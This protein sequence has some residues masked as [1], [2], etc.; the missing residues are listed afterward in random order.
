MNTIDVF[1]LIV[2]LFFLVRGIFHG[3]V[4]ELTTLIGL[5]LG[6]LVAISN[7]GLL[8][9]LILRFFPDL[10]HSA[11]NIFSFALLF[12]GTNIA[13]RLLS[14]VITKALKFAMLGW[15]NRLLGG[16]FG[17][18]KSIIIMS[19][20]VLLI[21]FLPFSDY[22]IEN[23]T[24]KGSQLFPLLDLLGPELYKQLNNLSTML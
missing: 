1:I 9:N 5:V 19:L 20:I 3:F 7:V 22:L 8:S 24:V 6:Y 4:A 14:D 2:I 10:P 23:E 16:L 13:M 18:I 17:A 15:L 11:V 21:D 12:V